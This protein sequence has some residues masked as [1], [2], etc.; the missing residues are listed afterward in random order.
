[1][2]QKSL[3]ARKH[4]VKD[5]IHFNNLGITQIVKKIIE[6]LIMANILIFMIQYTILI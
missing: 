5:G 4:I 6:F 3:D 2:L 1:M